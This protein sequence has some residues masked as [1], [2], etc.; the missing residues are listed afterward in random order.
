MGKYLYGASVQGIQEFIFATNKLQEIV[1][2]SEIVKNISE[3][4]MRFSEIPENQ[5]LVNAA[6]NIKAIFTDKIL[7]EKVVSGFAKKIQQSAYGIT[8]SQA[9]V[10]IGEEVTQEDI[11]RLES[12]LKTQ[13]NKPSIS[14]DLSI[15]IMQLSPS[16]AKAS[17]DVKGGEQSATASVQKREA[18]L[19]KENPAF[20]EL[21][22][23]SAI[24]NNNNKIAIIH[25][26]GN[27]LGQL[28][29]TL[30]T[31][32]SEFSKQLDIATKMAFDEA[33]I[34]I[35]KIRPIILG[36]D[37]MSV[38]CDA[39]DALEFTRKFLHAFEVETEKSTGHRLTACAG[40]AF[41]NEK[42]PFHY[43]VEL[44]EELCAHA[45]KESKNLIQNPDLP[46]PSSLM[47][48]NIQ[49]SNFQSWEKF[50]EDE[51]TIHNDK[52]IIELTFGPYYL[53]QS[54]Q[55]LIQDFQHLTN[56]LALEGSPIA[57]LR[58]WVGELHKN[59]LLAQ[60]MIERIDDMAGIRKGYKKEPLDN[61]F[62]KIHSD[63]SLRMP[64][65]NNKTPIY[66]VLQILSVTEE[67]A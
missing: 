62:R 41:C 20:A 67:K 53:S 19:R 61:A 8:I 34:G 44:A 59:D 18:Y 4:F 58:S 29:P 47:F 37:D 9:V 11:N 38:I 40:I 31:K 25:A 56:A 49:S 24:S 33:S 64:I 13:R 45:K 16:T 14:L 36:G 5:I 27:G 57:N 60:K 42:Y 2:A 1:G 54:D 21:K 63:L 65:T 50:I 7:L 3:E 28:I 30:G 66:D 17:I 22:E 23:L 46:A 55:P 48:H 6:G 35:K 52:R 39:N 43:G 10:K 32:L 15:S 51:L 26:D 12:R